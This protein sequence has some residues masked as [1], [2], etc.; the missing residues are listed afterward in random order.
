MYHDKNIKAPVQA[1][2]NIMEKWDFSLTKRKLQETENSNWS[3][4]RVYKAVE[5][6]K[7]YLAVTKALDGVQLVPN[8]DIDEVWH[9]HI[10]DTRRYVEDCKILFGG[11]LH[12]Y[13]FYGMLGEDNKNDWL[14]NQKNSNALWISLFNEP[15]YSTSNK[16]QKCPQ[17]CPCNINGH[18][19]TGIDY[20]YNIIA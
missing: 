20:N 11:F 12:H 6:Y 4:E 3:D 7:K 1:A 15:L 17:A 13:P 5:D 19:I 10:M 14:E 8:A 16:G 9:Y 18:E 2:L